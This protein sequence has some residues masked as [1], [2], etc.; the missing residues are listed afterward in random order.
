MMPHELRSISCY[1]V[2]ALLAEWLAR[3]ALA[4]VGRHTPNPAARYAR[5]Q[6][7]SH[8]GGR[9]NGGRS[10][11]SDGAQIMRTQVPVYCRRER[12]ARSWH[13]NAPFPKK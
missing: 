5:A 11:E 13:T 7:R 3:R 9:C 1:K 2:C 10:R 8:G 6:Q 12:A 4:S